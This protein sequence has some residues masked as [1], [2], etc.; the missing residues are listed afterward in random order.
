MA[1]LLAVLLL[2]ILVII[3]LALASANDMAVHIN[4]FFGTLELALSQALAL[5]LLVGAVLGVAVSL[6]PLWRARLEAA[7]LR[8]NMRRKNA[9]TQ[10]KDSA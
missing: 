1:R 5:A 3:G 8:R 6:P 10:I 9:D 4:F 7:R 2:V